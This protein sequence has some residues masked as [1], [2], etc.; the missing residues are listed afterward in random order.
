MDSALSAP[1]TVLIVDDTP[2][3]IEILS[4]ILGAEYEV[5]FATSGR[6]ALDL[7]ARQIPDL[8]LLDIMMPAMDGYEVCK[9]LK[10]NPQ[11][12]NVPVIFITALSEEADEARGLEV[13]AIDYISKPISAP[14]VKARVRNHLQLKRYRD[15]LEDLTA[16][17]GLTGIANRRRLDEFLAQEWLRGRRTQSPLSICLTDIDFFKRFNGCYGHA[18]GDDCLR[19]V[20]L[21]LASVSRRPADLVAR[22]GGE[23][24]VCVLPDTDAAGAALLA[25][26]FSD[27]VIAL[28]IP[29]ADSTVAGHVTISG[30]VATAI[31]TEESSAAQL[32]EAA[33][34][35]LYQA[36]KT[37]R[38]RV[39][40]PLW[41][42]VHC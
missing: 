13:G 1:Q 28:G 7:V 26:K 35:M 20:A 24:F 6:E 32:L 16:R 12:R 25:D 19:R 39:L 23:E 8:I 10:A 36:K 37:G 11:T 18:A 15:I 30:G 40:A 33:D 29:H 41:E 22:Y 5:L 3:N 9:Q 4:S 14:I 2:A 31:P 21:A 27:A 34:R 17:D 42:T 38:N